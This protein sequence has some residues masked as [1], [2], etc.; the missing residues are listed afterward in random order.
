[1]ADDLQKFQ[2]DLKGFA[3]LVDRTLS[4][5]TRLI[6]LDM[7]NEITVRNPVD[8]GYSR[9]NWNIAQGEPDKTIHGTKPKK[10]DN[11]LKDI[12]GRPSDL[13][14]MKE[15]DGRQPI[16]VTNAVGYVQYLEEGS[17]KQAPSGFIR[18][19]VAKIEAKVEYYIEK[20]KA[21]ARK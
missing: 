9:G 3:K 2:A 1:M 11:A 19:S 8:T 6:T 5:V 12:V 18:I 14:V 15:I 21:M 7:Y 4:E 20:A 17:S 16:F 13:G 10:G